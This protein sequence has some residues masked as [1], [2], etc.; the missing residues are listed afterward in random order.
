M[1]YRILILTIVAIR[2]PIVKEQDYGITYLIGL[3]DPYAL[4]T[5]GAWMRPGNDTWKQRRGDHLVKNKI[6][7][8]I[9]R[10][11]YTEYRKN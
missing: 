3:P 8:H 1:A 2:S 11:N 7:K 4:E 5:A 6:K 10:K 9:P